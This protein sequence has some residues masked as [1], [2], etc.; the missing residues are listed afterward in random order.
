MPAAARSRSSPA[1]AQVI[2]EN[3]ALARLLR[4]RRGEARRFAAG[5]GL[6]EIPREAFHPVPAGAG[7]QRHHDVIALAAGGL[8][9]AVEA[10]LLQAVAN[11]QRRLADAFQRHA[12]IRIE[13]EDDLVRRFDGFDRRAPEVNLDRAELD[14]RRQPIEVADEEQFL[15]ILVADPVDRLGHA[16]MA[17]FWKKEWPPMPFGARTRLSGL[18]MTCGAITGQTVA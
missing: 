14:Q 15:A 17:C 1:V 9:Q 7:L 11:G 13:I 18:S 6:G 4:Q 5:Q 8:E 3:L 2:D 10:D 16:G 12:R